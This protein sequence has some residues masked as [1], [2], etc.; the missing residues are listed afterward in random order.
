MLK[1]AYTESGLHLE[2]LSQSVEEWI[3]L[4]VVLALRTNQRL[5]VEHNRAS[6]L[7][8]V[9][10]ANLSTLK[11]LLQPEDTETITLS[12]CD[13]E[14]IEVSLTGVWITSQVDATEGMFVASLSTNTE[15]TLLQLWQDSQSRMFPLWR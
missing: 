12:V 2:C 11:T 7:I 13:K 15:L 4:C 10:L 3:A 6:I 14:F 8:P 5:I 1:V 9:A